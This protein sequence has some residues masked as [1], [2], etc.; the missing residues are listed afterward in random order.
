MQN[1]LLQPIGWVRNDV[2]L[3]KHTA[4]AEE[5][6]TILLDQ[7]YYGGLKGLEDFSH[8][9]ILCYLDKARYDRQRH[10]LRRPQNREDMPVVG[11]FSQR[12]KDRPNTIGVTSVEILSVTEESIT[13]RGLDALDGTPVLDIKP[14]YPAFDKREATV[15]EWVDR[16]MAHYF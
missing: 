13:V 3:K 9:I 4:W 8:A 16:L 2:S 15:P 6:S 14:Y 1:M 7:D 10:L 11:I 12:T 5:V